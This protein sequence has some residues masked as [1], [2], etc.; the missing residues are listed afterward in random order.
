ML[1][2]KVR[3]KFDIF[4]DKPDRGKSEKTKIKIIQEFTSENACFI[5]QITPFLFKQAVSSFHQRKPL[6]SS[7]G[8]RFLKTHEVDVFHYK[9]TL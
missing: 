8:K 2:G 7:W 3:K 1:Q 9:N 4:N 6:T 5:L